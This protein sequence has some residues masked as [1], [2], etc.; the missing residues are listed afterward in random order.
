[1]QVLQKKAYFICGKRICSK[2]KFAF[3]INAESCK[4]VKEV[5]DKIL[6][7]YRLVYM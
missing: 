4:E 2:L 7:K 3:Q 1:M 5:N 6:W